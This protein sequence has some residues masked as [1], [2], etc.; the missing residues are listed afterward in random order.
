MPKIVEPRLIAGTVESQYPGFLSQPLE[1]MV[2]MSVADHHP[3][4]CGEKCRGS[5]VPDARTMSQSIILLLAVYG[6]RI[7]EV[8][9]L[10]L[11]DIFW[12]TELI[13]VRR[14][15]QRKVQDYPLTV[16]VGGA[17]LFK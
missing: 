2:S 11:D 5:L 3:Y 4:L 6:L 8:C 12:E 13:R 16:E 7:G 10:T 17:I 14:S 15:K 9:K 1:L